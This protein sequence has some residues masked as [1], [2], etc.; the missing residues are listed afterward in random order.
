MC[1][2]RG[3]RVRLARPRRT[4]PELSHRC[5]PEAAP[6]DAFR[7]A[8]LGLACASA[9]LTTAL[10]LSWRRGA[11][12]VPADADAATASSDEAAPDKRR[13]RPADRPFGREQLATPEFCLLAAWVV[14]GVFKAVFYLGTIYDWLARL[15]AA[16]W[17]PDL[18]SGLIVAGALWAPLIAWLFE[19]LGLWR[20]AQCVNFVGLASPP[21]RRSLASP[22][23]AVAAATR[24]IHVPAAASPRPVS[25]E[26]SPQVRRVRLRPG[27]AGA[28]RRRRALRRLPRRLLRRGPK[29][30]RPAL[31]TAEHRPVDGPP[32]HAHEPV[33][34]SAVSR[35]LVGGAGPLDRR[36]RH[37]LPPRAADGRVR[38]RAGRARRAASRRAVAADAD[39][40][41]RLNFPF[42]AKECDCTLSRVTGSVCAPA[43][44][45][46][47]SSARALAGRSLA[48]WRRSDPQTL[49]YIDARPPR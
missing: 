29:R 6:P 33:G 13:E 26:F 22:F 44:K 15:G 31:R 30:V 34:L 19:A 48:N 4:R 2:S 35:R 23:S 9:A 37:E 28:G 7:D 5:L 45:K 8:F 10:A 20:A 11:A 18:I 1:D 49:V 43:K 24:N 25:A 42:I 12:T 38:G 36:Q 27:G 3:W 17:V 46:A 40:K 41:T 32:L 39:A 16:P 47:P 14:V 21:R